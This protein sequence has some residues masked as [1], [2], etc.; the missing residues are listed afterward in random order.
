MTQ[1]QSL[2]HNARVNE[3]IELGLKLVLENGYPPA[4]AVRQLPTW[5][6]EDSQTVDSVWREGLRSLIAN[7]QSKGRQPNGR[8]MHNET[9]RG[10]NPK[11]FR[12]SSR[13][14][15]INLQVL[16]NTFYQGAD[17]REKPLIVFEM[18][19]VIQFEML[20]DVKTKA[21]DRRRTWGTAAR[22]E[23]AREGKKQIRHLSE[24]ALVRLERLANEMLGGDVS[25]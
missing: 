15:K 22:E 9:A 14:G 4:E 8:T 21:W 13:V 2:T 10:V 24:K 18:A 19:D 5:Q 1:D 16:E 25:E 23:L 12:P 6:A 17:G 3:L 11:R 7:G 20:A